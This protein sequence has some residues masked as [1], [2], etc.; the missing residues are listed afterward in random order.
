M[1]SIISLIVL[2][3]TLLILHDYFP[4]N[5]LADVFPANVLIVLIV[6]L[7][8]F[9]LAFKKHSDKEN[10]K[11]LAWQIFSTVYFLILLVLFTLLG[12]KSTTG[13]S[14]DNGFLWIVLLISI[15]EIKSQWKKVKLSEQN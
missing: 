8:L 2:F 7:Y 3:M 9:S 14:F 10:K 4:N 12:G 1:K 6:G 13:I 11:I 5:P 15:F